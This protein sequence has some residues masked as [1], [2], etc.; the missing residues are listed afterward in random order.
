MNRQVLIAP[1]IV[2]ARSVLVVLLLCAIV[3]PVSAADLTASSSLPKVN[4]H[5]GTQTI[6]QLK[7]ST[8]NFELNNLTTG[9]TP[10]AVLNGASQGSINIGSAD[11]G[12]G[13]DTGKANVGIGCNPNIDVSLCI[14]RKTDPTIRLIQDVLSSSQSKWDLTANPT[15]FR[16]MYVNGGT[17]PLHLSAD[18]PDGSFHM[19]ANGDVGVGTQSPAFPLHVVRNFDSGTL[20]RFQQTRPN[21]SVLV[22]FQNDAP[23]SGFN[24]CGF[25]Y[26][27]ND[28]AGAKTVVRLVSSLT[29]T[30]ANAATAAF[31]FQVL[32]NGVMGQTM[33]LQGNRV[34]IGTNA[35]TDLLRVLN[36]RCNGATWQNACSRDLKQDIVELSAEAAQQA[37]A[38]LNPVTYAY[39]AEPNDQRVGFIA[40][41]APALVSMPDGE[42]LCA[43]DIV[44][45]LTRVTQQQQATIASQQVRLDEKDREVAELQQR[46][47]AQDA[48]IA[49]IL[50]RLGEPVPTTVTAAA[51][52]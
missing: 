8:V 40:E 1:T 38:D 11:A 51:N 37:L 48:A 2:T 16:I 52:P 30:T 25:D 6:Y 31:Q 20:A 47:A 39:K 46:L 32:D 24:S 5:N 27:L 49:T 7:A 41:D 44:A 29:S 28:D 42:S 33:K 4:F 21:K 17:T 13:I 23:A 14:A 50:A 19:A 15:A 12:E 43:M 36:A 3:K 10:F 9:H 22:G 26:L 18:A 34:S 45:V 35:S